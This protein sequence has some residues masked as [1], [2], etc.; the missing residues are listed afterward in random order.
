[1][2]M[3]M[4]MMMMMTHRTSGGDI[5]NLCWFISSHVAVQCCSLSLRHYLAQILIL[6]GMLGM[7]PTQ[8]LKCLM[9]AL[10]WTP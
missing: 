10:Q 9:N 7:I 3:M 1:M 5:S 2:M 8:T 6:M 4:M